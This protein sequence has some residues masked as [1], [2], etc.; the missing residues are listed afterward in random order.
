MYVYDGLLVLFCKVCDEPTTGR[1][2]T[3]KTFP[4][5]LLLHL[6]SLFFV[7]LFSRFAYPV[8]RSPPFTRL[9]ARHDAGSRGGERKKVENE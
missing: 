6:V 5:L 8:V 3:R 2:I 1:L 9:V 7:A 4:Y